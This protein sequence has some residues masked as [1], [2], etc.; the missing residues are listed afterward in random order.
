VAHSG[1]DKS[2]VQKNAGIYVAI[3]TLSQR[4][5]S[6]SPRFLNNVVLVGKETQLGPD[7]SDIL[8]NEQ[9]RKCVS[10]WCQG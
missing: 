4:R 5:L 1:L 9:P 2:Y 7:R 8:V 3:V 6:T 10:I